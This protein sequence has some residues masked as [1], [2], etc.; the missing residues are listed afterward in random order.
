MNDQPEPT[1]RRKT[2]RVVLMVTAVLTAVLGAWMLANGECDSSQGDCDM[3]S[4]AGIV[5]VGFA[6]IV[7]LV[8]SAVAEIFLAIH[9]V[10]AW[11]RRRGEAD[12]PQ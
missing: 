12:L 5:F 7:G 6:L 1:L 11:A 3:E 4:L 10:S 8:G 2:Y 9:R